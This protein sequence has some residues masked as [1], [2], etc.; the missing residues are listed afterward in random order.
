MGWKFHG[1]F[2]FNLANCSCYLKCLRQSFM[3]CFSRL[4]IWRKLTSYFKTRLALALLK[5]LTECLSESSGTVGWSERGKQSAVKYS[6][7][8]GASQKQV[9]FRPAPPS[10]VGEG[11]LGSSRR[12]VSQSS[13]VARDTQGLVS[14]CSYTMRPSIHSCQAPRQ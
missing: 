3:G 1:T 4:L 8:N 5:G 7:S 12:E 10:K 2:H 14:L 6:G 13:Q 9:S 11:D